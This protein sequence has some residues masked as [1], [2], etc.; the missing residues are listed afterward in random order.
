MTLVP[1]FGT[2]LVR[3]RLLW[4]LLAQR[5]LEI[6]V[7]RSLVARKFWVLQVA[8][9]NPAAPTKFRNIFVG[10][11]FNRTSSL[12]LACGNLFPALDC[13]AIANEVA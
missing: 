1:R 9:S 11:D 6:G 12:F 8:G 5:P 3:T 2:G 4:A 10:L 7:W 13:A